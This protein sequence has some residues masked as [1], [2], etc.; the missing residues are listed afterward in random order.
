MNKIILTENDL[1]EMINMAVSRLLDEGV[2]YTYNGN[3]TIN[4]R[5]NSLQADSANTEVDTRIWGTKNDVLNGDGTLGKRSK[6]IS[7]RVNE[8]EIA[9]QLYLKII[10]LL[11]NGAEKLDPKMLDVMPNGASKTAFV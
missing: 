4:A 5:V 10:G 7:Q 3:G 2:E 11:E 6:S 1:R 9:Q 8:M